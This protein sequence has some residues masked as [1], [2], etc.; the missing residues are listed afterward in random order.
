MEIKILNATGP[1][2][3]EFDIC[4]VLLLSGSS[5][6][7]TGG[8]GEPRSAGRTWILEM[9]VGLWYPTGWCCLA[10]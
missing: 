2:C 10:D 8:T 7:V 4:S 3:S 9:Q 6:G 1:I 5:T